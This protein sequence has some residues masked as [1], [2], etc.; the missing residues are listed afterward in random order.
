M[1]KRDSD[2]VGECR[3]V[4]GVNL[5]DLLRANSRYLLDYGGHRKACGFTV[6]DGRADA[7]IA[8]AKDYAARHFLGKITETRE[9]VADALVPLG[10]VTED[11]RR[12]SPLGEGNPQPLL[13]AMNT[14]LQRR[15][16]V[17]TSLA[18]QHLKLF[19]D[20]DIMPGHYDLL[21]SLDDNLN[22]HL[23]QL[24]STGSL[25]YHR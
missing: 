19:G 16:N 14:V 2:W 12:L 8:A 25:S 7:F 20:E 9:P 17:V 22:V 24:E 3:G 4:E 18:A 10:E 5:V 1:G 13:V 6:S 11:F 23:E 21:Y 15:G